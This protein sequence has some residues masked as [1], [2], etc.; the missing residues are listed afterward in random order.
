[1]QEQKLMSDMWKLIKA[2]QCLRMFREHRLLM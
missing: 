1:M 2:S